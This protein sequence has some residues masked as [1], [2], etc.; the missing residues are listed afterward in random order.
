MLN[1]S[2]GVVQRVIAATLNLR[3]TPKLHFVFSDSLRKSMEMSDLIRKARD[4]DLDHTEKDP[5]SDE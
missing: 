1:N 2:A 4:S 3:Y 5:E